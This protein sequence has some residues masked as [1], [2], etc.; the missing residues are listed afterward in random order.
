MILPKSGAHYSFRN[1]HG[2]LDPTNLGTRTLEFPKQTVAP[3]AAIEE[4]VEIPENHGT[5]V[6]FIGKL[7]MLLIHVDSQLEH[8]DFQSEFSDVKWKT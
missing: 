5:S 8:G 3:Q 2:P 7:V 1:S 4:K 6:I